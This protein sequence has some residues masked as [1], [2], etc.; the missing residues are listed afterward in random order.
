IHTIEFAP[1]FQI[2]IS[3]K[4]SYWYIRIGPSV[5]YAFYG[6][7]KFDT[8]PDGGTVKRKILFDFTAY[9]HFT[10]SANIQV[11]YQLPD[12][13]SFFAH[14]LYGLGSFNNADNG[15][16]ILHR[17]VGVSAAWMFPELHPKPKKR[18]PRWQYMK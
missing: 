15:P 12:G 6:T 9:G 17:V 14:Y 13:L 3:K 16:K 5:D 4:T 2:D 8:L 1:L 11:G 18:M 7:E 10:A